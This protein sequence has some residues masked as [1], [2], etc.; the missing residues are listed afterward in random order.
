MATNFHSD[1]PNDQIHNPKDFS[2]AQTSSVMSKDVDGALKWASVPYDL[3]TTITCGQDV[4]GSLHNLYFTIC[5]DEVNKL[6]V[7]FSVTGETAPYTP[8]TT[9]TQST[10]TVAPNDTAIAVAAAIKTE[11][12]HV[13]ATDPKFSFTTTLSGTGKVTFSGMRNADNTKD[14]DTGMMILNNKSF[15][16]E[17]E[18]TS[19][20]NGNISFKPY[21]FDQSFRMFGELRNTNVHLLNLSRVPNHFQLDTG[22]TGNPLLGANAVNSSIYNAQNKDSFNRFFGTVT[23]SG[24]VTIGLLYYDITCSSVI[25]AA[26][27]NLIGVTS[28][29]TLAPNK[30]ECFEITATKV[31]NEASLIV[32]YIAGTGEPTVFIQSRLLINKFKN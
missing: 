7:H 26:P 24:V 9:Y 3:E 15:S 16:G 8:Y 29:I 20:V 14:G 5:H 30:V 23:G 21:I 17:H 11:L 2:L 4:A 13:T 27:G 12:D 31:F 22:A 6:E 1:L 10:V 32:P 25:T 28:P 18:L 19:D